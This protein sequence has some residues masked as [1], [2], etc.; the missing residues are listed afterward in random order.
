M[1][2]SGGDE[3]QLRQVLAYLQRQGFGAAEQALKAELQQRCR[4]RS[5]PSW[6]PASML[7]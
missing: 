4:S 7:R 3:P 5:Q 2:D 1:E 6:H